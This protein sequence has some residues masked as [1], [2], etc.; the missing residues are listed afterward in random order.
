MAFAAHPD[1]F[2]AVRGFRHALPLENI[3]TGLSRG[4]PR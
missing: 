3:C 1:T 4:L 2:A